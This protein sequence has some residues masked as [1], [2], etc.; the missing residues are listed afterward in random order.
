LAKV[1]EPSREIWR[2]FK[3][4]KK[5]FYPHIW[6]LEN[7]IIEKEFSHKKRNPA[8]FKEKLERAGGRKMVLPTFYYDPVA[9]VP[10]KGV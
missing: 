1:L 10:L 4:K 8:W 9:K 2:I 6:R 3:G 7:Q 5:K